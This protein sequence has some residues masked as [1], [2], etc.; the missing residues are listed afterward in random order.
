MV[1]HGT[2]CACVA[3]SPLLASLSCACVM[4]MMWHQLAEA[5]REKRR[6][7][8]HFNQYGAAGGPPVPSRSHSSAFNN[9]RRGE[10]DNGVGMR[11]Q[12]GAGE[13]D[14]YAKWGSIS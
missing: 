13:R 1:W 9:G 8:Q 3:R 4:T 12:G 6:L 2:N 11:G 5:I 10:Y 7:R 14:K